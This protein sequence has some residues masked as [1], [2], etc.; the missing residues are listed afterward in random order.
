MTEEEK[1]KII[2]KYKLEQLAD[3]EEYKKKQ[4]HRTLI[5]IIILLV[6]EIVLIKLA[7]GFGL[8]IVKGN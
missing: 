5:A 6:G 4:I 2:L 7:I 3:M 8:I 1:E